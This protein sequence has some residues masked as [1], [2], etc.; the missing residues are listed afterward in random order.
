MKKIFLLLLLSKLASAQVDS[1]AV[2]TSKA[3]IRNAIN[4]EVIV[5]ATRAH[6]NSPT[7]FQVIGKA[8]LNENNLGQDLPYMLDMN[9]SVVITS[10]AGNGIGYTDIHIR[11]VDNSRINVTLNGVPV[12]DG[13]D[14]G[15]WYVDIPDV[16]SS[17]EDIQIQ[18]GVGTSTNGP[19]A[20][21]GSISLQTQDPSE[22]AFGEADIS[23][24]SFKT[25]KGTAKAGTGVLKSG[26]FAEGSASY[27]TSNGYVDRAF[28]N[29]HS[30]F[31]QTGY[32]GKNTLLKLLYF[33]GREKT[34]QA[35]DG[36]PQDSLATH[37]TYN[38]LG[39]DG[40]LLDPPYP[41]QT[42]N[43]AQDY[44]QLLLWQRLPKNMNLNVG[45]FATLGRGYYEEYVVNDNYAFYNI[46]PLI[47]NGDTSYTGNVIRQLWLKNVFYGSTFSL[48]YHN[49]KGFSMTFGG[50]LS[51]YRGQN[52][53]VAVWAQGNPPF[54]P[55][56]PYYN[57]NSIKNDFN[58]YA[59][60]NYE[61]VQKVNFYLDL[62][63]RYLNY[64][65]SGTDD[66]KTP[67]NIAEIWNFF[68]PKFG[69]MYKPNYQN[70]VYASFALG[71][72]EPNRDDLLAALPNQL[73]TPEQLRDVEVGYKFIHRQFP[74]MIDYY[75]MDYKNQLV[76]TGELNDVGQSIEQNV[77]VSYRTGV[78][79][80]GAINFFKGSNA[81]PIVP[82]KV[83]DIKYT[84]AWSLNKI[85]SFNEYIYTYDP[86]YN[87]IDTLTLVVHHTNTDISFSP[88][89]VASLVLTAY[90]VKGLSISIMN[91]AV[92]KQF[93][94]NTSNPG[95]E[96]P[97]FY[98]TNVNISYVLPIKRPVI[99]LKLLINN[100]FNV[101]Y[102]NSGSSYTERYAN[103]DTNGNL[104]ITPTATYNYYFPQAGTNVLAGVNVRF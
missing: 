11:G 34:Y 14:Q 63:Y 51:Q 102:S 88:D 58:V 98:Y 20:F 93:L 65:T 45:L 79:I 96:L 68:N 13:E 19:G 99:T 62:Q 66:T 12:N 27:I 4:G 39:T 95:R 83:F 92:S 84:F 90:P 2:D 70:Q 44:L 26:F 38:D 76:L 81:K 28:S 21:G 87:P 47:A 36:V 61:L 71:N 74:F 78:E 22:K 67:Y 1:T 64:T 55:N 73:P 53:G 43:Y 69:I 97:A 3:R 54:N 16:V 31:F 6:E 17:T 24:G 104:Q 75:M 40:G 41:N 100:I 50:L 30:W 48:D 29:L 103:Y 80:G 94:D 25:F 85:Q 33:G 5:S 32:K 9:P 101:L 7:T 42:D 91:K 8:E 18:R 23:G 15:V 37:R 56:S 52:Y 77:P 86:N 59:K 60:F 49:N 89:F 72:R 10:N 35:W 46:P 82:E 57:G